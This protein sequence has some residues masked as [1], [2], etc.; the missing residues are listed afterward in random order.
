MGGSE[1]YRASNTNSDISYPGGSFDPMGM[2]D[3]PNALAELKV[4]ELKNGRLAMLSMLG[5]YIQGL[6]NR[7]RPVE[8][9]STHIADPT[10]ANLFAYTSDL[11]MFASA[12][13][14]L[15]AWYGPER[16]K[17][18][19]PYSE[20][21]TPAYLTGELPGDYGWDSA[22]LGADPTTLAA[23]REAELIHARWTVLGTLRIVD[24]DVLG[25]SA[26]AAGRVCAVLRAAPPPSTKV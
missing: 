3:D 18:L 24:R 15:A 9:W 6:V 17:W 23:Y 22:G 16:N 2:A 21:S 14:K 4:K 25:G 11:A 1:A 5:Y 26:T 20:A 19:G 13:D 10:S 12:G 7:Q 8:N